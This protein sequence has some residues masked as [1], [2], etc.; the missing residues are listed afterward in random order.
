[1]N[2][3]T[4]YINTVSLVP[5]ETYVD[6]F[7]LLL[8]LSAALWLLHRKYNQ[9]HLVLSNFEDSALY[10]P[11]YSPAA[12]CS[13]HQLLS[14]RV[15]GTAFFVSILFINIIRT[16]AKCIVMYTTWNMMLQSIYFF[17][18][19]W[20]TYD[21]I[22]KRKIHEEA[23]YV[24]LE[25]RAETS[26]DSIGDNMM[27]TRQWRRS[28]LRLELIFDVCL[29][30]SILLAVVVWSILYPE[31]VRDHK[32]GKVVNIISFFE[33][34]VNILWLIADFTCTQH[35]IS[36]N[37]IPFLLLWPTMYT[38][39]IWF[40]HEII[41]HEFWP[42]PF[43]KVDTPLSPLWYAGLLLSH[44]AT[45]MLV[46]L[47]SRLRSKYRAT[48]RALVVKVDGDSIEEERVRINEIFLD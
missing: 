41:K 34:G 44:L 47:A 35:V 24:A 30:T 21:L 5:W 18:S 20:R 31:A 27:A 48:S 6:L 25:E 29:A 9:D 33:H 43:M 26:F 10:S 15:L 39:F 32:A 17:A 12:W 14:F 2:S 16:H 28:W 45:F 37:A 36:L 22:Q 8:V 3:I 42:Y 38:I 46:Y 7:E 1:M 13:I 23:L 11:L 19:T 40:M 4:S